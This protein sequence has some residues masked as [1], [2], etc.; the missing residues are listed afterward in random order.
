[1]TPDWLG[2]PQHLLGG[3]AVAAGVTVL[4][5]R[6]GVRPW[7][8]VAL[9]VGAALVAEAVVEVLE[10]WLF[11]AHL[12]V[13]SAA[14]TYYDTLADLAST[15]LGA[16]AGGVLAA[17]AGARHRDLRVGTPTT[18]GRTTGGLRDPPRRV[19]HPRR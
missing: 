4:S 2:S 19:L 1:M 9:G 12:G 11:N 16:I 6:L 3:G 13:G 17:L 5:L 14:R 18:G 8:C 7:I 10:Y 15:L